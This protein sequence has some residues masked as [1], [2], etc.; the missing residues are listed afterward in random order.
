MLQQLRRLT[1]EGRQ[2]N[3]PSDGCVLEDEAEAEE[4]ELLAKGKVGAGQGA[5]DP[6]PTIFGKAPSLRL[7]KLTRIG[8]SQLQND[9]KHPERTAREKGAEK[10]RRGRAR[11]KAAARGR[12]QTRET[13]R[14]IAIF[15][16]RR[17][18]AP[19]ATV[20]SLTPVDKLPRL[21]PAGSRC[22]RTR[23]FS[24]KT[25]TIIAP[26]ACPQGTR[27]LSE[28]TTALPESRRRSPD[29]ASG[30]DSARGLSSTP[31]S[32]GNTSWRPHG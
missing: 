6:S 18:R 19:E 12:V 31:W 21:F 3:H 11:A 16:W 25:T 27:R 23:L 24:E 15:G 22:G 2:K 8:T 7:R 4:M 9:G 26:P 20:L 14:A 28:A 17:A 30:G 32:V 29:D 5:A 13:A 10:A 1:E